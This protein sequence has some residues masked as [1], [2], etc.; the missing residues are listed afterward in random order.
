[1]AESNPETQIR[2]CSICSHLAEYQHGFQKGGRE[3]EDTFLPSEAYQ[4]KLV[5]EIRPNGGNRVWDL[6]QCPECG[7][8]YEYRTD[9]EFL[10]SGTE[11]EQELSRLTDQEAAELLAK[12]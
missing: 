2:A 7:T 3:E 9:Y 6:K 4:L 11:D 8:Y 1:M 12:P 5:R 10:I